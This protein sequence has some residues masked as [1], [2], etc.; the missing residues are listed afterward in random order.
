[1]GRRVAVHA[2]T[3]AMQRH[4]RRASAD[5]RPIEGNPM[6][7]SLV[8]TLPAK[9]QP[10]AKTYTA[11]LLSALVTVSALVDLPEWLTVVLAVLTAPLVFAVPNL[12][13]AAR[14]QDESVQ[15]PETY[16]GKHEAT[17]HDGQ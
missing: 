10:Y 17:Y 15:P 5:A 8:S 9:W 13:P 4:P 6:L 16:G 14:K 1:M 7:T 12:D 3:Q 2:R 11:A